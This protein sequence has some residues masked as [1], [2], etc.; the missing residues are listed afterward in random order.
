MRDGRNPRNGNEPSHACS[1]RASARH[2]RSRARTSSN[3]PSGD[4]RFNHRQRH[5]ECEVGGTAASRR[6]QRTNGGALPADR[7]K[8]AQRSGR[9]GLP[10]QRRA[11]RHRSAGARSRDGK[12]RSSSKQGVDRSKSNG[13]ATALQAARGGA[14]GPPGSAVGVASTGD[15][16]E[17]TVH[18]LRSMDAKACWHGSPELTRRRRSNSMR[19]ATP[20]ALRAS[21]LP[22][23]RGSRSP[24][25]RSR[26]RAESGRPSNGSRKLPGLYQLCHRA[27]GQH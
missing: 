16:K 12:P 24:Q 25:T 14:F 15:R 27:A 19:R 9:A 2:A 5:G 6:N 7:P 3:P 21:P 17:P 18:Q 8:R 1:R 10:G 11:A 20:S 23:Q 4:G 26:A 13:R 22:S